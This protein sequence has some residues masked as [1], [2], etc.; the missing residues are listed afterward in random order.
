MSADDARAFM[1]GHRGDAPARARGRRDRR[2]RAARRRRRPRRTGCTGRR[3]PGP[4]PIVVYFHGGG[5]VLGSH[6]SDD[7]FCRDLCVRSDAVIVSVDYRHAPEARFP[8]A[9]DDAFAA[10]QWIA[11]HADRARRH[12]RPARR[13]RLE[14]RR[15]PR[16]R[17]LPAGPRRRRPGASSGSCCSR[18]V[19]DCDLTPAVVRRERRRLRPHHG[20]DGVVLGPLRRPG[21]P[22]RP[23]R[24]AAA[25]RDLSGLPPALVVTARVRP[26][27]RRGRRLRRRPGGRR[28]AGPPHPGP[29]PHPH[30]ADHGRRGPLRRTGP[31]RDGRG[32]WGFLPGRRAAAGRNAASRWPNRRCRVS[33]P[34]RWGAGSP[35]TSTAWIRVPDP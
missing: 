14:R 17:R 22:R 27:A 13:R 32:A 29:R 25:R 24:L 7:P 30:V 34:T 20:A 31:R 8:A 19:T 4:H 26:A 18:P 3:R 10:V 35:G 21:R 6:D 2:R 9:A 23:A 33:T 12:P 28:R 15:Q 5:W 11:A 16:R 1:A